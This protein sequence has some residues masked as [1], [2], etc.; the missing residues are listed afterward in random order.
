MFLTKKFR[1][2]GSGVTFLNFLNVIIKHTKIKNIFDIIKVLKFI[3][4]NKCS[5]KMF[6]MNFLI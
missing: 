2:K 6:L 3:Q 4:P 1:K 5:H